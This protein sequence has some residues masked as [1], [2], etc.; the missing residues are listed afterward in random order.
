MKNL[1]YNLEEI[2]SIASEIIANSKTNIICLYG[3]M[4][5][6]K[7]TLVKALLKRIGVID[8]GNSPTF[9]LVNEYSDSN[10]TLAFHF[11]LYR[12]NDFEEALD[13]GIEEYFSLGKYIFIE[14]PEVIKELLPD[15]RTEL[16]IS[17]RED[18]KREILLINCD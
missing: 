4:G 9:G 12:I 3:E 8:P 7:T 14:W 18:L 10:D 16:Y 5:A 1:I 6:G 2:D 17:V 11:D 13:I 15:T